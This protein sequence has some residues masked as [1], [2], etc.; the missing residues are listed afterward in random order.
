MATLALSFDNYTSAFPLEKHRAPHAAEVFY[1]CLPFLPCHS[2][3]GN[4]IA[5]S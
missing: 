5:G 3:G 2:R 1:V 4:S